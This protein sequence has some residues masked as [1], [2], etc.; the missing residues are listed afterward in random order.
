MVGRSRADH[1]DAADLAVLD[2]KRFADENAARPVEARIAVLGAVRE[3][4][5]V[6]RALIEDDVRPDDAALGVDERIAALVDVLHDVVEAHL[7]LRQA[8]H[9]RTD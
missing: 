8:V 6:H 5:L 7:E 9:R 2:Q 3:H 4:A 1:L